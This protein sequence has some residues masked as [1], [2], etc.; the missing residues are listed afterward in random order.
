MRKAIF[1]GLVFLMTLAV[2][3]IAG[4]VY[5]LW[6]FGRDLPDYRQLATYEPP[7]VTRVH[8]GDGRLLA[9]YAA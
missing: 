2:V 7:T 5:V 1:H 4:I 8:A 6:T 3:G 9:E